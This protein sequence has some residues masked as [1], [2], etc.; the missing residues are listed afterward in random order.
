M[1][2]NLIR[3][4]PALEFMA[5]ARP[6]YLHTSGRPNRC[7]PKGVDCLYFAETKGTATV[8]FERSWAGTSA[9]HQP[10]LTYTARVH[11]K[12]IVDLASEITID[13]LGLTDDDLYGSW[14]LAKD[15]TRLQLLGLAISRQTAIAAIRYRSAAA[16]ASASGREGWN[17]AVF[18]AA[19]AAPDRV[20][21]LG[22]SPEPL[23]V[24]P[25]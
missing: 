20:E 25:R 11:L 9:E 15:P 1:Q 5:A 21:I 22:N 23:E 16:H 2:R 17:V 24:L 4:V 18:P 7:N 10:Q 8:E 3:C 6:W 19:V 14:R 13:A 12:R